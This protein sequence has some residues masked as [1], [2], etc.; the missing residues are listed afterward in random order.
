MEKL[1]PTKSI[2]LMKNLGYEKVISLSSK[3]KKERLIY[4]AQKLSDAKILELI[5]QIPEKELIEIIEQNTDEQLIYYIHSLSIEDELKIFMPEAKI[6]RMDLDTVRSKN[7]HA[8]IINDFE[9][10]RLNILVGTQMVTKGLDFEKASH[11]GVL[12]VLN[13]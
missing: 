3:L 9:E 6:G 12:L 11:C 7:A 1:G 4:L 5:T 2:Q 13:V 10:G 8:K